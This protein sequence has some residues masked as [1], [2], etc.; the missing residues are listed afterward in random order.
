M[1]VKATARSFINNTIRE[2]GEI[3]EYDGPPGD[4][5]IP[6]EVEKPKGKR[7]KPEQDLTDTE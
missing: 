1:L 4:H 7:S 6:Q 5:L 2:E 3:F